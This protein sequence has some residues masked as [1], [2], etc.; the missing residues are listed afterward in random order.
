[1]E[2]R[3]GVAKLE[4]CMRSLPKTALRVVVITSRE[5]VEREL[6]AIAESE[7]WAD[8]P[9]GTVIIAAVPEVR[10]DLFVFYQK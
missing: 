1:M 5:G 9:S 8:D 7:Y 10:C 4:A 2:G 6:A 3:A